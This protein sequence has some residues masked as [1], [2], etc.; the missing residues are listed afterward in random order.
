MLSVSLPLWVNSSSSVAPKGQRSE[1]EGRQAVPLRFALPSGQQR[2]GGE[3]PLPLRGN[4]G[5]RQAVA[6]RAKT[7]Q[8]RCLCPTGNSLSLPS[9]VF[10][11]WAT[12][13]RTLY[14]AQRA[15]QQRS[16]CPLRGAIAVALCCPIRGKAKP[17]GT[18]CLFRSSKG[19]T[20][21]EGKA[22]ACISFPS[23][24]PL[25]GNEQS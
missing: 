17:K 16:C 2:T 13:K 14:V 3:L 24:L 25:R 6:R 23:V 21:T 19:A 10:A 5:K 22:H 9:V 7:R 1:P 4:V 12:A 20:K 18:A 15:K 11:L 8:L